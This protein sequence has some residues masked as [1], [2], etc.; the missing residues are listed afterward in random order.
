MI[1]RIS[2]RAEIYAEALFSSLPPLALKPLPPEAQETPREPLTP[3]EPP[4]PKESEIPQEPEKL[5]ASD[6]PDFARGPGKEAPPPPIAPKNPESLEGVLQ[7]LQELSAAL[8]SPGASPGGSPGRERDFLLSP[9]LSAQVKKRAFDGVSLS[10]PLVKNFLFVLIDNDAVCLLPQITEAFRN[11][12]NN[13]L[14]AEE[15]EIVSAAPVPIEEKSRLEEA[16]K[17]FCNKKSLRLQQKIDPSLIGG[18]FIRTRDFIVNDAL[19][20][21]LK[22]FETKSN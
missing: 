9:V 17:V 1:S 22:Q 3:K 10:S 15:G 7:Q 13:R 12:L 16:L 4:T 6:R 19:S 5:S 11:L 21:H 14:D 20:F 8:A 2:S 18:V